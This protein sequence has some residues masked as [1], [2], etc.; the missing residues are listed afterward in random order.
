MKKLVQA[1]RQ[2]APFDVSGETPRFERLP[3]LAI[4]LPKTG[5]V[6]EVESGPRKL[7]V[8]LQELA[9]MARIREAVHQLRLFNRADMRLDARERITRMI[10]AETATVIA[11]TYKKHVHAGGGLPEGEERR[12]ALGNCIALLEELITSCKHLFKHDYAL[13]DRKY[14][15]SRERIYANGVRILELVRWEQRFLAL[16]YQQL[17]DKSWREANQVFFAL[18]C[19]EDPD[20]R[21]PL[22]RDLEWCRSRE[23]GGGRAEAS[24]SEL[25]VSLQVFGVLDVVSWPANLTRAVDSCLCRLRE[26]LRP[27]LDEGEALGE[28]EV[29][30]HATQ[31]RPATFR[32]EPAAS[33]PQVILDLAP[34]D[35]YL[36]R[37]HDELEQKT[38]VG[39]SDWKMLPDPLS[40]IPAGDALGMLRFM[41]GRLRARE[42]KEQR[43]PRF[44]QE[45]QRIYPGF[46]ECYRLFRD[47]AQSGSMEVQENRLFRDALAG[48]SAALADRSADESESRWWVVDDS[49]GGMLVTTKE[50]RYAVPMDVGQ[51]VAFAPDE[52]ETPPRVGYITRMQRRRQGYIDIAVVKI[53]STVEHIFLQR[54]AGE[55]KEQR[56]PA[57]LIRSLANEWQVI[58]PPRRFFV[59]GA[60]LI[61]GRGGEQMPLRLGEL[62]IGRREFLVFQARSPGL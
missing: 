32:R 4:Y 20:R 43:F 42:R 34:L 13:S 28:N 59:S 21:V 27:R 36:R 29:V 31:N 2:L 39:I 22:I 19:V 33:P 7:Q 40:R 55:G 30:I 23:Q 14:R 18:A 50:T 10:I 35:R 17:S 56:Y 45:S 62:C 5:R 44:Q 15:A 37:L 12:D 60:P 47:Q 61:M 49:D 54:P 1:F 41:C 53:A 9:P 26:Q 48:H 58:V 8:R 6:Q 57:L 3:H 16:R 46:V 24:L 11:D 38:F 51:L 52:C 25:F